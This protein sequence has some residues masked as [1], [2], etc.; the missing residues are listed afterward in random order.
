MDTAPG[1]IRKVN[2]TN[3]VG[4]NK[5]MRFFFL[6]STGTRN[7]QL[8]RLDT[9]GLNVLWKILYFRVGQE[10]FAVSGLE[11]LREMDPE[12]FHK[13]PCVADI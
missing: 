3:V 13:P 2:M 10:G 11:M 9:T 8:D 12:M 1:T 6:G 4:F 7:A 5:C